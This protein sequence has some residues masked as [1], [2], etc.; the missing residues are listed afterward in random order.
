MKRQLFIL[1]REI[2]RSTDIDELNATRDAMIEMDIFKPPYA[3][4][5]I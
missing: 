5:S 1:S 3:E 4:F 2:I